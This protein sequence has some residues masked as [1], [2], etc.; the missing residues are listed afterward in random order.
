MGRGAT[1]GG[2]SVA[3]TCSGYSGLLASAPTVLLYHW[4]LLGPL[5]SMTADWSVRGGG[6]AGDFVRG[7]STW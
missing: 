6:E 1:R 7:G 4:R 3:L 5:Y 2:D